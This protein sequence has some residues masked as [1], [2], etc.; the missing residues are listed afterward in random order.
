MENQEESRY[1]L[2][3]NFCDKCDDFCDSVARSVI[4]KENRQ[5]A[6][7]H[8]Y[9]EAGVKGLLAAILK[10]KRKNAKV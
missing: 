8:R 10:N 1:K 3:G 5:N 6:S 2:R 4:N 9:K 7:I